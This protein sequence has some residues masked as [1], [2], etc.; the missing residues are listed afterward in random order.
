MTRFSA[1]ALSGLC[2]QEQLDLLDSVDTLR[3]QGI[4]HYI[5]LPQ[6]IVCGDQSSGKSSVLEAISGVAFSVKSSLCT[7]FPT[8]LVLRKSGRIGVSVSIVPHQSHT[9]SEKQSLGDFREN[10]DSFDGLPELIENAKAVMGISTHGK[11]FSNDLLRV[12]VSG[13]DRPHLT[14]VDLPGLIHSETKQQSAADVKLVQDCHPAVVSAKNDFA[15]QIVLNLA[16]NADGSGLRTLGVITKPDTLIPGSESES[17]FVSL[18]KNQDVIF[19][20]GW[21]VLRNRDTE[22]DKGTLSERNTQEQQFFSQGVWE[23]MPRALVGIDT[24]RDRLSKLLLAQIASELPS[25]IDEIESYLF[26]ISQSFQSI[27]KAAVDGTYNHHFF[28]DVKKKTGIQKRIRAVIQNLNEDF[29]QHMRLHGHYRHICHQDEKKKKVATAQILITREHFIQHIGKLVKQTRGRELPGTF[30]PMIISDLFMEQCNPWEEITRKHISQVG[31]AVKVFIGLAV[32]YVADKATSAAL[33]RDIFHPQ[34]DELQ[35]AVEAKTSDLL[36][37]HREGHPI[38]YNH[39]FTENLQKI[40]HQRR[41]SEVLQS[42]QGFFNVSNVDSPYEQSGPIK[43]RELFNSIMQN[44]EPDMCRFASAEALHCML[45]YYKVAM[46]RFIDDI[47]IE[48]IEGTLVTSLSDLFSPVSVF[49]MPPDTITRIAGESEENRS[50]REQL[51]KKLDVLLKG[52]ETCKKF[53]RIRTI[54]V[55]DMR[56]SSDSGNKLPESPLSTQEADSEQ[57]GESSRFCSVGNRVGS[58]IYLQEDSESTMMALVNPPYSDPINEPDKP[59]INSEM[60]AGDQDEDDLPTWKDLMKKAKTLKKDI[61][62]QKKQ[63]SFLVDIA[64]SP[65]GKLLDEVPAEYLRKAEE[66]A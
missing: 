17:M 40:R 15:N 30:N 41:E 64:K 34:L 19:N 31:H 55:E 36:K 49:Q 58:E 7:R 63:K 32:S 11:A 2:T 43:L 38:T 62:K 50:L 16:R 65:D 28:E 27:V 23:C 54:A 13:P 42:I 4:S 14:I 61:K 1:D 21:H 3:L 53:V 22:Q 56:Y 33:M 39:Y 18:A 46:K 20:L 52:S 57:L 25:L 24:L 47:A 6:I 45:A 10:L 8:E 37:P 29:A 35:Q 48:V 59:T 51:T 60:L 26:Q 5:S 12:E 66:V 9:D 44:R